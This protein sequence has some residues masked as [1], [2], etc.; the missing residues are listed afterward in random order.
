MEAYEIG[1]HLLQSYLCHQYIHMGVP[2]GPIL[3]PVRL[4]AH[5]PTGHLIINSSQ[6]PSDARG[7]E[8]HLQFKQ[9]Q[10]LNQTLV[11]NTWSPG[12]RALPP[13]NPGD[14]GPLLLSLPN[15]VHH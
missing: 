3:V 10:C 9:E 6:N 11:E 13:Q 4:F 12:V 15:I 8:P 5:Q 14:L 2:P 1:L 7:H